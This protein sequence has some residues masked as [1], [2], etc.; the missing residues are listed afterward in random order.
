[1]MDPWGQ[2]LVFLSGRKA[3]PADA[4]PD[5]VEGRLFVDHVCG[6]CVRP[7]RVFQAKCMVS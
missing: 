6:T 3:A 1:M 5:L 7:M 4:L 2:S